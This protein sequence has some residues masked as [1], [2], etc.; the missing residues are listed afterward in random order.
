MVM[1][2]PAGHAATEDEL[3]ARILADPELVLGDRDLMHALVIA[4]ERAMGSNIVDLRGMAME[5][6]EARLDSLRK[7]IAP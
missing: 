4:N 2:D 3:R 7:R 6:L 5:R 1:A